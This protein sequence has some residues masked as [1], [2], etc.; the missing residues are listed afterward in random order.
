MEAQI[1]KIYREDQL[2]GATCPRCLC[3]Y[4]LFSEQKAKPPTRTACLLASNATGW[5]A[6]TGGQG[7]AVRKAFSLK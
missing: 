3:N 5:P 4:M 2:G 1:I 7:P 6:T